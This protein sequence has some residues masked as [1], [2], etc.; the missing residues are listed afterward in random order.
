MKLLFVDGP[1]GGYDSSNHEFIPTRE[2]NEL[3][4]SYWCLNMD[5][6]G[7]DQ[8]PSEELPGQMN[9]D[10]TLYLAHRQEPSLPNYEDRAGGELS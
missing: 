5:P 4:E 7:I 8:V 10:G 2:S 6:N 9:S 1:S 3:Q